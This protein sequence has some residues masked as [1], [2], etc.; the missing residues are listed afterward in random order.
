[1]ALGEDLRCY[2]EG[3]PIG[4]RRTSQ[5]DLF[6]RW[7]R[8][9]PA[10]ATACGSTAAAL[11]LGLLLFGW[12]WLR[13]EEL[14]EQ[15]GQ[16]ATVAKQQAERANESNAWALGAVKQLL[17]EMHEATHAV[18]APELHQTHLR[19][20]EKG[21]MIQEDLI[22]R[23]ETDLRPMPERIAAWVQLAN[24]RRDAKN[25]VG[26]EAAFRQ[27]LELIRQLPAAEQSQCYDQ[28]LI[29]TREYAKLCAADRWSLAAESFTELF[30]ALNR[31][32]ERDSGRFF[33]G[34]AYS[35]YANLLWM[36]GRADE[37][38]RYF[39]KAEEA[40][41]AALP[42]LEAGNAHLECQC[43]F[44]AG[45]NNVQW[46]AL[47]YRQ[48]RPAEELACYERAVEHA[49]HLLAKK[50]ADPLFRKLLVH[51]YQGVGDGRRRRGE[52]APAEQAYAESA[53]HGAWLV[54]RHAHESDF[55]VLH[56][57]GL[58]NA[59][60]VQAAQKRLHRAVDLAHQ[61]ARHAAQAV[62]QNPA[63][64]LN[65][66]SWR[67]TARTLLDYAGKLG[68]SL[69]LAEAARLVADG[70]DSEAGETLFLAA[71]SHALAAQ[72]ARAAP[73]RSLQYETLALI[74]LQ[75][76]AQG[77]F[78]DAQRLETAEAFA[79]LRQRH[80]YQQVLNQLKNNSS[81]GQPDGKR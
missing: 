46:A 38:D 27:A 73:E 60:V 80:E 74:E 16:Q 59:A 44:I 26:A 22:R 6:W 12:Q 30:E 53:R 24:L 40:L 56:A 23:G 67:T 20:S 5:W 35:D 7:C 54:Q 64:A 2:L 17:D 32:P 57:R 62:C 4:A 69:T 39:A 78:T 9:Y 1:M 68:D 33:E 71:T 19:L 50:P 42:V 43:R 10:L 13:A 45:Q 49:R 55:H 65:Q 18:E 70:P 28:R 37:A 72:L 34:Q 81:K 3:R 51:A 8:R 58:N 41:V 36:R 11:V 14:A 15:A 25:L 29:A 31:S 75:R 76:A 79:P 21:V 63:A 61:A 66:R 48:Q 47:L 52:W 77:G